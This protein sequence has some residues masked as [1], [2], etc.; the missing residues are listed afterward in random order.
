V[1]SRLLGTA[2]PY[3]R[4]RLQPPVAQGGQ[5]GRVPSDWERVA[6]DPALLAAV[7]RRYTG[8]GDV[9]DQLW[10]VEHPGTAAPSGAEDPAVRLEQERRAL[11]RPGATTRT[12]GTL[13]QEEAALRADRAAARRALDD[14]DS[15]SDRAPRPTT[16]AG[17]QRNA[18]RRAVAA[19][20]IAALL[21]GGAAGL[22]VGRSGIASRPAALEVFDRGQREA[23]RPPAS[24]T[25]PES[26]RPDTLRQL[27]AASSSG[28]VLYGAMTHEGRICLLAIVL[29]VDYVVTCS[30][31]A[32]FAASGLTLGFEARVDPVDDSP[33]VPV[34]QLSSTWSPDGRVH[35]GALSAPG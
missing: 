28:T 12:A 6:A 3:G 22:V 27:G 2:E 10:W 23:D 1:R 25:I 7:R 35:F 30:T 19:A 15:D 16:P 32:A 5:T 31:E 20:A 34:Q 11:Y 21:V 24:V 29:A 4:N 18:P 14:S 17:A 26:V 9:L 8:S 33:V 13:Q